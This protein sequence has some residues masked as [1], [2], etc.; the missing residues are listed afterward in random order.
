MLALDII[1]DLLGFA[2]AVLLAVPPLR[3]LS[4]RKVIGFLLPTRQSRA[5]RRAAKLAADYAA[6]E[7]V[8]FRPGDRRCIVGGLAAIAASYLLHMGGLV[9]SDHAAHRDAAVPLAAPD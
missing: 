8:T 3:D 1:V 4:W 5:L 6:A 2:G 7:T 9:V